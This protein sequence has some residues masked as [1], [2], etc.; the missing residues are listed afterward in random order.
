MTFLE[1]RWT[2]AVDEKK[3]EKTVLAATRQTLCSVQSTGFLQFSAFRNAAA[4]HC[5]L[6]AGKLLSMRFRPVFLY[7][8]RLLVESFG[9]FHLPLKSVIPSDLSDCVLIHDFN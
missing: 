6:W 4:L 8:L 9:A 1:I 3:P 7:E 5:K 2:E